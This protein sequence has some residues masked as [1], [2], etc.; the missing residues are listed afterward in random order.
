MY[1]S[2]K[3][4]VAV[5]IGAAVLGYGL[6]YATVPE[7]RERPFLVF[8]A[9]AAKTALWV[10]MFAESEEPECRNTIVAVPP[11]EPVID[12]ARSL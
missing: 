7:C 8:L 2:K 10:M 5:V 4:I 1:L 11:D 9:K 12:H 3:L 6:R